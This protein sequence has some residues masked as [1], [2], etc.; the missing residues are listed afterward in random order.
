MERIREEFIS[1]PNQDLLIETRKRDAA[2]VYRCRGAFS[3]VNHERLK[4]FEAD[5]ATVEAARIV[6]DLRD[7]SFLDSSGL[8]TLASAL[9]KVME[10]GK[11]LVLVPNPTVRRTFATAG[12]EGVFHFADSVDDA[13][14]SPA[15]R[16]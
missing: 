1:K 10:Q 13:L 2:I 12:L 15:H 6:I 7:V 8:G 16:P 4:E 14:H 11:E 3:L 9:K 5:L